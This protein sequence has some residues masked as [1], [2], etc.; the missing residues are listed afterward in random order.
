MERTRSWERITQTGRNIAAGW[1]SLG[2]KYQIPM[3]VFGMPAMIKFEFESPNALAYKTLV[4]QEMLGKGYLAGNS[5]YVCTE[6]TPE[7]ISG[8]FEALDS[9]FALIQECHQGRDVMKL[10]KG[11]ICHADFKRL[12]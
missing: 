6:H 12:N 3:R 5:V 7:I 10:L 9:V 1:Q 8:Y 11:P 2:D 4:T